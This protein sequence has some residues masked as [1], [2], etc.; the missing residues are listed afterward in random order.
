[1]ELKTK[2]TGERHIKGKEWYVE[3]MPMEEGFIGKYYENGKERLELSISKEYD[4]YKRK[5]IIGENEDI[6]SNIEETV[7]EIQLWLKLLQKME[8]L[9]KK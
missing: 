2:D 3:L 7:E 5:V 1:M 8:E 6:K 4:I 9:E